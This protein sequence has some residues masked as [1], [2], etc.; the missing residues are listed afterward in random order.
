[1]N[2]EQFEQ[3]KIEIQTADKTTDR[4]YSFNNFM[5]AINVAIIAGVIKLAI[6]NLFQL[7]IFVSIIGFLLTVIWILQIQN[8]QKMIKI[9]YDIIKEI[10]NK[11]KDELI[12]VFNHEHSKRDDYEKLGCFVKF[13]ILE[14]AIVSIFIIAYLFSIFFFYHQ[15]IIY[16]NF[17]CLPFVF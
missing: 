17:Y 16:E 8:F 10:E 1:M 9:K 3:Y 11:Y 6:E 2:N 13:S 12:T 7:A 14:K 5:S 4:R 15:F